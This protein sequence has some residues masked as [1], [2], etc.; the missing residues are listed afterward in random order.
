MKKNIIGYITVLKGYLFFLIN[1]IYALTNPVSY[2]GKDGLL[3]SII[4]NNTLIPLI[5][6]LV[7]MILGYII[8]Y[9]G[10]KGES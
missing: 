3:V 7:W 5:I 2:N 6:S 4:Y 9:K 1:Y 8:C 10:M